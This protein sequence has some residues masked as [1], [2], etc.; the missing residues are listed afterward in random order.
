MWWAGSLS[1]LQPATQQL[2]GCSPLWKNSKHTLTQH[3]DW[4]K[5]YSK[6]LTAVFRHCNIVVKYLEHLKCF[7][8]IDFVEINHGF[9]SSC[10]ANAQYDTIPQTIQSLFCAALNIYH[11]PQVSPDTPYCHCSTPL[12]P[13]GPDC[14]LIC[15][16]PVF[17]TGYEIALNPLVLPQVAALMDVLEAMS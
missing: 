4:Q 7:C 3:K 17:L 13:Y 9:S 10:F 6:I 8:V 15:P 2:I 1:T 12:P 16:N 14:P 11:L 5:G